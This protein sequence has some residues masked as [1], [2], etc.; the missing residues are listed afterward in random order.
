MIS[1]FRAIDG[2]A[3]ASTTHDGV[4]DKLNTIQVFVGVV[5][6]PLLATRVPSDVTPRDLAAFLHFADGFADRDLRAISG[7]GH[8]L[9]LDTPL[10]TACKVRDPTVRFT[11]RLRGGADGGGGAVT[12]IAAEIAARIKGHR[13]SAEAAAQRASDEHDA[14]K[15]FAAKVQQYE[16]LAMMHEAKAEQYEAEA[17]QYED[18]T[19]QKAKAEMDKTKAEMNK[20][21]AEMDKAEAKMN[22]AT[23]E[24]D[25]DAKARAKTEYETAAKLHRALVD[26]MAGQAATGG[27]GGGAG[28]CVSAFPLW[29]NPV[30]RCLT[31]CSSPRRDNPLIVRAPARPPAE[32]GGAAGECLRRVRVCVRNT[33]PRCPSVPLLAPTCSADHSFFDSCA[34]FRLHTLSISGVHSGQSSQI[35]CAP[36]HI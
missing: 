12:T 25:D 33:H 20:T 5:G 18:G 17:K 29:R 7:T 8:V 2:C 14:V 11:G 36:C 22:K 30:A 34:S 6:G 24:R 21:K 28:E 4:S 19:P 3:S 26:Q 13:L 27:G 1:S 15:Q 10:G 32:G 23:A 31:R 9:P 35:G 16:Y